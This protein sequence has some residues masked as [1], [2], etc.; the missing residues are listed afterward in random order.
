MAR[1]QDSEATYQLDRF[2]CHC[3]FNEKKKESGKKNPPLCER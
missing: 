3:D 2:R 1:W